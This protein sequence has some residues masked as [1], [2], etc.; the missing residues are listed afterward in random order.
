[1]FTVTPVGVY[2]HL[3]RVFDIP[4]ESESATVGVTG[5]TGVVGVV[6]VVRVIGVV[7][8]VGLLPVNSNV[9]I[10]GAEPCGIVVPT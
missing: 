6:G 4:S 2:G 1:M 8:V 10:S 9:P 5:V 3:S 7:G